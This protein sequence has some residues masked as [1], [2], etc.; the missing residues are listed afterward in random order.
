MIF[1][2]FTYSSLGWKFQNQD[3]QGKSSQQVCWFQNLS[4]LSNVWFSSF[5]WFSRFYFQDQVSKSCFVSFPCLGF[6]IVPPGLVYHTHSSLVFQAWF[7]FRFPRRFHEPWWFSKSGFSKKVTQF[8]EPLKF[9]LHSF[10]SVVIYFQFSRSDFKS[11]GFS[12]SFLFLQ[13]IMSQ[14]GFPCQDSFLK[15]LPSP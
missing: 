11:V 13:E 12:A 9:C 1:A 6:R 8:L 3:F 14:T 10:L 7:C 15:R 2:S 4:V 5:L